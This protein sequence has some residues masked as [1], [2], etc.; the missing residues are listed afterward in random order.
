LIQ[1]GLPLQSDLW[2]LFISVKAPRSKILPKYDHELF[3]DGN[4]PTVVD[5]VQ[6]QRGTGNKEEDIVRWGEQRFRWP[7]EVRG[8]QVFVQHSLGSFTQADP[9]ANQILVSELVR[10][11]DSIRPSPQVGVELY[12][13]SGNLSVAWPKTLRQLST[14]ESDPKMVR[15]LQE[16]L[17][18]P[19]VDELKAI[20]ADLSLGLPEELV[21]QTAP[22]DV[23][24]LDPPR[25]G[26]RAVVKDLGDW[27]PAYVAYVSCNTATLSRDLEDLAKAG[28][29]PRDV[30]AVDM[31]PGTPHVEAI[32]LLERSV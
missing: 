24:L 8:D 22:P 31:F 13:G 7:V 19:E 2:S 28:Y 4:R 29:H 9:G 23:V 32:V 3:R 16:S 15:L 30:R 17:L 11:L 12:A 10:V 27:G 25:E 1:V 5:G 18:L 20:Q 26:A 21:S 6:I 14:Y